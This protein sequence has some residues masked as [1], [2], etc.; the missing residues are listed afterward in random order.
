MPADNGAG[1]DSQQPV[2]PEVEPID[3]TGTPAFEE[4]EVLPSVRQEHS[5][6]G[7][8]GEVYVI[9]GFTPS[10][11][12]SVQ[13][14]NPELDNWRDVAD[15]PETLHHASVATVGDEL[16]VLGFNRGG[17]FSDIDGRVFAYNATA[18]EWTPRTPMPDGTERSSS[19]IAALGTKIY[20]IAGSLNTNGNTT[21]VVHS[22]VYDTVLDEWEILPDAPSPREHCIAGAVGG[23]V[24]VVSGRDGRI[25]GVDPETWEFDPATNEFSQRAPIP[26]PRG[27]TAGAVL[28]NK[29]YIF[30]GEG[31]DADPNG[32]FHAVEAYVPSTDT[33]E[34]LPNMLIGRH[35]FAAAVVGDRIY[36]PG[37]ADSQGFGAAEYHTV[38]FFE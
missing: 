20:L 30:G 24:Y 17:G 29:I 36:L 38:F 6:I 25:S 4:R 9:G 26:T 8:D 23:K 22:S 15:F 37:G 7:F 19:C 14:Y 5:A 12:A 21:A 18:D 13:V 28:G 1:G 35:G 2:A 33:W 27:G 31:N 34:T 16:Y 32:I 11:T 10:V 3:P